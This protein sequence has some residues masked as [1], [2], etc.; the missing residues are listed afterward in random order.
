[1]A[2]AYVS[3]V[4]VA[5]VASAA[6]MFGLPREDLP[7]HMLGH[8]CTHTPNLITEAQGDELMRV[9]K[10]IGEFQTNTRSAVVKSVTYEH[11]GEAQPL[12]PDGCPHPLLVPN[13]NRTHCIFPGRVDVGKH[14]L[15]YGGVGALKQNIKD[16]TSRVLTFGRFVYNLDEYPIMR[17]LFEAPE[18]QKSAKRICPKHQQTLDPLQFNIIINIP[19]QSVALHIDSVHF[20]GANRFRFPEWLLAAMSFS[21]MWGDKFVH[22]VQTVGYFHRWTDETK[23]SGASGGSAN[24]TGHSGGDYVFYDT[25]GKPQRHPPSPLGAISLDGTKVV[26]AADTYYSHITPPRIDKSKLTSIK[27]DGGRQRWLLISGGQE[28]ASYAT[29]DLRLSIVYRARCF[30]S[31]EART[32]FHNLG[33]EDKLSLDEILAKFR[34]DLQKRGKLTAEEAAE[35]DRL[36]LGLRILDTYIRY[37]LPEDRLAIPVNYCAAQISAPAWFDP[38]FTA[39]RC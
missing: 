23:Q 29:D 2:K 33:E 20:W 21:G 12:G 17:E 13:L 8:E 7:V 36:L 28:L 35:D 39:L 14:F 3:V 32:K 11:I 19:G 26:H 37:P 22:Q 24:F 34:E 16:M 18:F 38:L 9:A 4:L 5:L 30:E 25:N 6:V 15:A 27:W 1:M 10:D 31:E